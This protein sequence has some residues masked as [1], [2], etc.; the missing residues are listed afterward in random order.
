MGIG[1]SKGLVLP[2]TLGG[3]IFTA[4]AALGIATLGVVGVYSELASGNTRTSYTGMV[5]DKIT[6]NVRNRSG[7]TDS[8]YYVQIITEGGLKV[9]M[10]DDESSGL[11]RIVD[12]SPYHVMGVGKRYDVDTWG[13][14]DEPTGNY[15]HITSF[16]PE[17]VP[18]VEK[19]QPL[20]EMP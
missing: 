12:G 17:Y 6:N 2:E 1:E 11:D 18:P 20:A 4:I 10:I 5:S 9:T 19:A 13:W 15:P 3:K 14:H 8:T 16:S 7:W